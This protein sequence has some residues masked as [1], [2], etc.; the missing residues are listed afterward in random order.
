MDM[1]GDFSR[2]EVY[3]ARMHMFL[4]L[5]ESSHFS[6]F[7]LIFSGAIRIR[8]KLCMI[9]CI[10]LF[11]LLVKNSPLSAQPLNLNQN[12]LLQAQQFIQSG[13][14]NKALDILLPLEAELAGSVDYDYL[15]GIS[16]IDAGHPSDAVFALQRV[17][18]LK[19]NYAGARMDLARA[20]YALDELEQAK[21]EFHY[22]EN[23]YP[24]ENVKATIDIYLS[25]IQNKNR[26]KN[27]HLDGFFILGLGSDSNA[28]NGIDFNSLAAPTP[29]GAVPLA[30]NSEAIATESS[31]RMAGTGISYKYPVSR[32][33]LV[34]AS[35]NIYQ[36]SY[37]DAQ[38][39]N[40]FIY[41]LATDYRQQQAS[42]NAFVLGLQTYSADSNGEFN[43]QGIMLSAIYESILNKTNRL[44]LLARIADISYSDEFSARDVRQSTLGLN[45]QS[46]FKSK[47][48]SMLNTSFSF[49]TDTTI[50]AN[51]LYARNF[52]IIRSSYS[53]RFAKKFDLYVSLGYL[54]SN[55]DQSFTVADARSDT[56]LDFRLG[57]NWHALKKWTL[58]SNITQIQ[59]DSNEENFVYDKLEIMLVA[60]TNFTL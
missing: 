53:H 32:S 49:S 60:R 45:W 42:G 23:L 27:S 10:S 1:L 54:Q 44:N 31:L 30:N 25:A 20:Y 59:N 46:V 56:Q 9:C 52:Y 14:A 29:N 35:A 39:A 5:I 55:Y 43:N 57:V 6:L 41:A 17:L 50:E 4:T 58:S 16:L 36:K 38:F 2:L 3:A 15:L 12:S 7:N 33:Q 40:S 47:T 21:N 8:C 51:S 37:P 19:P 13:Q 22:L 34:S 48:L 11:L 28:N 18:A 24:P 26:A